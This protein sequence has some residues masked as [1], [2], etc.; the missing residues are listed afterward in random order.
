MPPHIPTVCNS[1]QITRPDFQLEPQ[2][3][4]VSSVRIMLSIMALKENGAIKRIRQAAWQEN[5]LCPFPLDA[6]VQI[7]SCAQWRFMS[8]PMG[9]W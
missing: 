9:A 7:Q 1:A 6:S 4:G 5:C 3:R 2:T 8:A